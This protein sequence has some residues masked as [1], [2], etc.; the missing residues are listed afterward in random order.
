MLTLVT[1]PDCHMCGHGRA[2]L[3]SLAADGRFQWREVSTAAPEGSRLAASLPPLRPVLLDDQGDVIA[4]G[5]LSARR[6]RRK[7]RHCA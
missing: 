3:E 7:L 1:S 5:R 4:Y 6:L 2:V